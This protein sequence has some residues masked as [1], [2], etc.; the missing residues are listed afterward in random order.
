MRSHV[1]HI[2]KEDFL[3]AFFAAFQSSMTAKN[4][5]GGFRGAGI[6]PLDPETVISR[7]DVKPQT[8]TPI[9]GVPKMPTPW[10][11]RTPNNPTEATSQSEYIKNRIAQHQN[12]SPMSIYNTID[13]F[14]KGA[15][16]IM[17]KIALLQ[18]EN[19]I[20]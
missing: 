14:S 17:H 11:S 5:Q 7:L 19:W 18:S 16:G 6:V 20:L 8:P 4:I 1:T 9:E 13:R 15:Q 10:V 3:P 2:T 12:S